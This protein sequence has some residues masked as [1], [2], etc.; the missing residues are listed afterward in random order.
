MSTIFDVLSLSFFLSFLSIQPQSQG[1]GSPILK[2]DV[3]EDSD[4]DDESLPVRKKPSNKLAN[5]FGEAPPSKN[6]KLSKFFGTEGTKEV[7]KQKPAYLL[8]NFGPGELV[9]NMEGKVK[10]GTLPA[11]IER[12]TQHDTVDTEFLNSF[13]LTYKSFTTAEIILNII[14][15]RFYV[16][17]P[18]DLTEEQIAEFNEKKLMP[19]RLR[20]TNVLKTWLETYYE[21]FAQA[22]LFKKL[23][24]FVSGD[25]KLHLKNPAEQILKLI[26]KKLTGTLS[27]KMVF[28][29]QAPLPIVSKSLSATKLKFVELDPLEI[30]RQVPPP[31]IPFCLI[32]SKK[33]HTL[34]FHFLSD[35]LT[36]MNSENLAFLFIS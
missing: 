34:C 32:N 1:Q 16:T 36:L 13:L 10:G 17:P 35:Q 4:S 30:A 8:P 6:N 26:Q 14:I 15:Q 11:L 2:K 28:S 18:P 19:I 7:A 5:F 3:F 22:A 31:L 23:S 20:V 9:F 24:D 27:R 33:T 25:L 21:D 29:G 12:L